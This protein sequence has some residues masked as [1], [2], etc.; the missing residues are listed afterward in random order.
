MAQQQLGRIQ[1][2]DLVFGPGSPYSVSAIEGLDDLPEI[3]SEDVERPNQ[4]G[5]YTGPDFT[6][7][8][9][10]PLKLGLRADSP[11]G[12]RELSIALRNATQPQRQPEPLQFLDWDLMVW[13]KVRRRSIPY[14]AEYLWRIGDAALE[15]YCADPYLYGLEE[16]SAWTTAY[17]PSSGRA[18]PLSYSDV[19]PATNLVLNPSAAVDLSNTANYG[20]SI[21]R[22]R[23]TTDAW[24]GD[25]SILHT[26]SSNTIA[27]SQWTIAPLSSGETI[28]IGAWVKPLTGSYVRGNLAWRSGSTTLQTA[29]LTAQTAGVWSRVTAT[30]TLT[31]GQSCDNIGLSFEPTAT[32]ATW[33][34]D[35]AMASATAT[36]PPY[37]DGSMTNYGWA[38]TGTANASSSVRTITGTDRVYGSAGT[39]G[40]LTAV[41]N[42]ASPAYP[43]LRLDG[44]VATPAIEQVNTGAILTLDATLQAGEYLLID[45]RSRAVLLGGSSPRRSW[46]RAGSVW[47][48]LQP[49]SN[50]IAYRG[51][52][53]PGAPGQTS[54]L[55]VTWRDTSL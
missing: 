54:L 11:D 33:L 7:A 12:L 9:V 29:A 36:L 8:R 41:N 31:A 3:R 20:A 34:A 14:D 21:T 55:T 32:G 50:E 24:H 46:V 26:H 28:S 42:G 48:V 35:A 37:G 17:S 40:R 44:P 43:I 2:G 13:A 18:Y 27:G 22:T 53:L 1:W 38:W 49:G 23:V 10:I 19:D 47:P 45:T 4:H 52:A 30:Y 16:K 51:S 15:F 5:D 39:S 6:K 25:S